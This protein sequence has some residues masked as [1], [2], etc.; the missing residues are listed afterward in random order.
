[1]NTDIPPPLMKRSV[2]YGQSRTF[3]LLRVVV[4]KIVR[5]QHQPEFRVNMMTIISLCVWRTFPWSR[6]ALPSPWGSSRFFCSRFGSVCMKCLTALLIPVM[7]ISSITL[8]CHSINQRPRRARWTN[9]IS[10]L[11][12][13]LVDV[14]QERSPQFQEETRLEHDLQS[15]N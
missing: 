3:R 5:W 7:H 11:Q 14:E 8:N 6:M 10:V 13:G 9:S 15:C 12:R 4:S 2:P 1:M